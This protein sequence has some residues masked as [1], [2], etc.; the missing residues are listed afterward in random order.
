LPSPCRAATLLHFATQE[1]VLVA[2]G[3]LLL[4]SGL[5]PNVLFGP[6]GAQRQHAR[7]IAAVWRRLLWRANAAAV[8]VERF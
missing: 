1:P 2:I 6:L 5:E 7:G 3:A 8:V 4:F